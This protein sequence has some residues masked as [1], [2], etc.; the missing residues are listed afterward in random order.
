MKRWCA[1]AALIPSLSWAAFPQVESEIT[2]ELT[3][4]GTSH[5]VSLPATLA[6]GNLIVVCFA[7]DGNPTV[8]WPG[9]PDYTEFVTIAIT[10]QSLHCAWKI[11]NGGEGASIT[12][13]TDVSEQSAHHAWEISGH[14]SGQA[15]ESAIANAATANPDPPNLTPTGGAK[16]FLWLVAG[17][18]NDPGTVTGFSTNY[19]STGQEQTNSGTAGSTIYWQRRE[20]NAAAEDPGTLTLTSTAWQVA[21]IA[22][23]PGSSCSG[24]PTITDVDTDEILTHTQANFTI[25][26][27][28]FCAAQGTGSVT[29][30]QSGN[31]KTISGCTWSDTSLT[32]CD[33]SGVGPGVADGLIDG[34]ADIRVTNDA[35]NSD[36]QAIT[37]TPPSGTTCTTLSGGLAGLVWDDYGNPSRLF[38]DPID[39]LAA[40]QVCIRNIQGTGSVTAN[41]DASLTIDDGVTA[42][43]WDYTDDD[44]SAASHL[45]IG[46]VATWGSLGIPPTVGGVAIT[47]HVLAVG[48]AMTSYDLDDYFVAGDGA[49][50]ARAMRQLGGATDT[51]TLV[52]GAATSSLTVVVDDASL[53]LDDVGGWVR[54]GA[55]GIPVRLKYADP[56]TNTLGLWDVRD[57][58][59]NDSV[60]TIAN[61]AGSVSGVAVN[62][63]TGVVDGTPDTDATTTSLVYRWTA[64]DTLF[65]ESQDP[66]QIDVVTAPDVT[67][68]DLATGQAALEALGIVVNTS[69]DCTVAEA[70]NEIL[71]QMESSVL[72]GTESNLVVAR[73]CGGRAFSDFNPRPLQ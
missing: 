25:T 19:L 60:F 46:T 23:H 42:F 36:D 13:T 58:A 26:G 69:F 57:A 40:S 61:G 1:L 34:S 29:L 5:T 28:T 3:T 16:D 31:S 6:S 64:D 71:T 50:S 45:F 7:T 14:D 70:V 10:T 72:F 49:A 38:G 2:S 39:L 56:L 63:G 51:T 15:P 47:D 44:G 32:G 33:M 54:F 17:S 20:L 48:L 67:A 22:I 21:T 9:A 35:T 37:L 55:G 43:D 11:S 73:T 68:D 41:A 18:G 30:R 27:T 24:T 53:L 65:T 59:D 8:T 4:N 12:V 62:S 66:F 52:N